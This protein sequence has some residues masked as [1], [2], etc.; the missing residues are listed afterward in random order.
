LPRW[1]SKAIGS[2]TKRDLI[3]A[4]D[5]VKARGTESAAHHLLA[6]TKGLF[7]YAIARDMI[8][9]SPCDRVKPS[10]LIGPKTHRQRVLNDDEIRA[11][12]LACERAGAF[13][14]LAQLILAT[15]TRRGEAA[16]AR[17][18]EFDDKLWTIPPERFKSNTTHLVPL[19]QLALDISA[20]VPF[21]VTGFSKSKQRLDKLML[22]ELRKRNAKAELPRW[23]LHDL[24]RTVRTR[25]SAITTY[26][27]AELVIG[28]G[29]KGLARVYDQH[30]YLDE[31][32]EALDAWA[33]RLTQI[34]TDKRA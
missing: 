27:V 17:S 14:K 6:Y 11:L 3:D 34:V 9:H 10:V 25:L 4:I 22:G 18:E 16:F 24:R 8:E 29:K 12:W 23:T 26:E 20:A 15:G 32:R 21:H 13:G 31:M 7:N 1:E 2:I 33:A 19:S 28:H 5:V 30:E